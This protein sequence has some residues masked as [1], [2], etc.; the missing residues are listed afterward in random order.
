VPVEVRP[1]IVSFAILK[2][3]IVA[4]TVAALDINFIKSLIIAVV[5]GSIGAAGAVI[6]AVIAVRSARDYREQVRDD[7]TDVKQKIG[8]DKRIG[9]GASTHG[10]STH[11][12]QIQLPRVDD[13]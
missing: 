1:F 3:G 8:A 6:A 2:G 4:L 5:S 11:E 12:S 10:A 7:I 9:D 13:L